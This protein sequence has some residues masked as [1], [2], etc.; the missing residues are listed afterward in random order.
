MW[1][2][3]GP[4]RRLIL[5]MTHQCWMWEWSG[6]Y[7]EIHFISLGMWGRVFGRN[8][9]HLFLNTVRS[10]P[11]FTAYTLGIYYYY[12][13]TNRTQW[14]SRTSV[15]WGTIT[16]ITQFCVLTHFT[17]RHNAKNLGRSILGVGFPVCYCAVR[18]LGNAHAVRCASYLD[19]HL[20]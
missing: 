15:A 19:M 14:W 1:W 7:S 11:P 10:I 3:T 16:R 20:D 12:Q 6:Q 8:K 18:I 13:C 2:N 4:W 5:T 17:W 9:L